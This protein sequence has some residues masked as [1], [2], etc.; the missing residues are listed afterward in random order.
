MYTS[1][2]EQFV[3]TVCCHCDQCFAL[4]ATRRCGSWSWSWNII[5]YL[6]LM[7]Q[8]GFSLQK[9]LYGLTSGSITCRVI[10][11]IRPF[12]FPWTFTGLCWKFNRWGWSGG[13]SMLSLNPNSIWNAIAFA[14][15][16]FSICHT[17]P[18]YSSNT[19]PRKSTSDMKVHL[20]IKP[21]KITLAYICKKKT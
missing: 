1:L 20:K 2:N 14:H 10:S 11:L 6:T 4:T 16:L 5:Q 19:V 21:K 7:L 17:R 8:T 13:E 3:H 15:I 9:Q 12:N 18:P